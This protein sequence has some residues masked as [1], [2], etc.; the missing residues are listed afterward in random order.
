M[1]TV[2][3][4]Q[5]DKL[6]DSSIPWFNWWDLASPHSSS[7]NDFA[8][9]NAH[10]SGKKAHPAQLEDSKTDVHEEDS[11][12]S[13]ISSISSM[14]EEMKKPIFGCGAICQKKLKSKQAL[15]E[16]RK[17][18]KQASRTNC[19]KVQKKPR[20]KV[21]ERKSIVWHFK[22]M[23]TSGSTFDWKCTKSLMI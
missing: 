21:K 23:P 20:N 16:H 18:C 12:D 7:P 8:L 9:L 22:F 13:T 4:G 17:G 19:N 11:L 1:A 10:N 3:I 14:K 15:G 6:D 2:G 5:A